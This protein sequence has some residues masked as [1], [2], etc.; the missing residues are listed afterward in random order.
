VVLVENAIQATPQ[1][2]RLWGNLGD[3]LR[4]I[5]DRSEDMQAAYRQAIDLAEEN[6]KIDPDDGYLLGRLSVYYAAMNE[7][8][9]A[10]ALIELAKKQAQNDI[11]ILFDI[12]V[13]LSILGEEQAA[14]EQ[15]EE[16][17]A[18]GYP[19]ALSDADPQFK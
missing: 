18:A 17:K 11:Y 19:T 1:D 3:I 5:P 6:R 2:H 9:K 12:A 13:A 14:T 4:F 8:A 10:Q 15:L 7:T 16:A